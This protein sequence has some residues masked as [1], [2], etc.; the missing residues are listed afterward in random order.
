MKSA[1]WAFGVRR[2]EDAP[3]PEIAKRVLPSQ[4]LS[5]EQASLETR[6]LVLLSEDVRSSL[7]QTM[8]LSREVEEGGFLFGRVF[9]DL[10]V[11]DRLLVLVTEAKR[12]TYAYGSREE[13]TF[14]AESFAELQRRLHEYDGEAGILGWYHTHLLPASEPEGLSVVDRDLHFTTFRRPWQVAG[15]LCVDPEQDP[16]GRRLSFYERQGEEMIRCA[17]EVLG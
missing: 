17:V 14:G 2:V 12:A 10:D 4:P 7:L 9:R 13:L 3:L 15:L 8:P 16:K 6:V 11:M 5:L 1:P